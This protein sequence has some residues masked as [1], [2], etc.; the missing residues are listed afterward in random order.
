MLPDKFRAEHVVQDFSVQ[1]TLLLAQ[2]VL[3]VNIKAHL[4]KAAVQRAHQA[5]MRQGQPLAALLAQLVSTKEAV[6]SLRV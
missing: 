3:Q 2:L 5:T 6:D 4:V 1:A